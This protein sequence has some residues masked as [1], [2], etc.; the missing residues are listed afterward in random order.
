MLTDQEIRAQLLEHARTDFNVF[1]ELAGYDVETGSPIVQSPAHRRWADL[2]DQYGRLVL[3][4]HVCSGATTQLAVLRTVWELGQD[5]TLRFLIVCAHP[6]RLL[7]EIRAFCMRAKVR[8]VFPSLEVE[9]EPAFAAEARAL[10]WTPP[11]ANGFSVCRSIS[12]RDPSVRC[13]RVF[14]ALTSCRIDRLIL[15][16]I[17]DLPR[18]DAPNAPLWDWYTSVACTRLTKRAKVLAYGGKIHRRDFLHRLSERPTFVS[19]TFPI[20]GPLG[21]SP[22]GEWPADRI[23]RMREELGPAEFDRSMRC[24]VPR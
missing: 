5:P 15:D 22:V 9:P 20:D 11:A 4:H 16:N 7:K 2:A 10:G 8:E 19:E 18:D 13:V 3:F 17:E 12:S 1:A 14:G 21:V 23:E 6:D 24:E